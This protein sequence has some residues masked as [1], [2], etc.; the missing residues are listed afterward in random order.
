MGYGMKVPFA[1]AGVKFDTIIN[2]IA[3][4]TSKLE[5]LDWLSYSR[6]YLPFRFSFLRTTQPRRQQLEILLVSF[7]ALPS[8]KKYQLYQIMLGIRENDDSISLV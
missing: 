8:N 7:P 6:V 3:K 4:S 2:V 1:S 5:F